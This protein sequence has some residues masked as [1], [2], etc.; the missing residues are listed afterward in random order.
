MTKRIDV[1]E[2]QHIIVRKAETL[3][4]G[5]DW[6][7]QE[8]EIW[9]P[10]APACSSNCADASH[11]LRCLRERYP[12]EG[13]SDSHMDPPGQNRIF[14]SLPALVY[15]HCL[16]APLNSG[17]H[18]WEPHGFCKHAPPHRLPPCATPHPLGRLL[19]LVCSCS[20]AEALLLPAQ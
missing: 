2:L 15:K 8:V 7:L 6:H 4:L 12:P 14:G 9:H 17:L 20:A 5:G 19:C 3:T 16:R 13:T 18:W 10:G 11:G 1:G